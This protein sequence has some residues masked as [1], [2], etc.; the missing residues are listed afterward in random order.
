MST[1][2]QIAALAL[3]VTVPFTLSACGTSFG[4]QTN[5]Q[6]QAAIGA[7]LRTGPIHVYNGLFVAN[8]S[9]PKAPSA[10]FSGAL[11]SSERQR[12]TEVGIEHDGTTATLDLADYAGPITLNADTLT[13]LGA[14]GEIVAAAEFLT[15]GNYVTVTFTSATG[16]TATVEV[17]VVDRTSVYDDVAREPVKAPTASASADA[18]A[19]DDAAGQ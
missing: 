2:R 14:D 4:A 19:E 12:I 13:T 3:A 9:D 17:P 6:Y 15:P 18:Q 16:D 10:T 1:R 7:N 8:D 11:L 5:Q